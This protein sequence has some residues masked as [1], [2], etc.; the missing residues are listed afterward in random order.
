MKVKLILPLF[1]LSSIFKNSFSLDFMIDSIEAE[2]EYLN[3]FENE[4]K[5]SL[6]SK[7]KLYDYDEDCLYFLNSF[8]E[9][10]PIIN[11]NI[12][13]LS[14][15]A[16]NYNKYLSELIYVKGNIEYLGL[17]TNKP[18][19][20]SGI[21]HFIISGF[22]GNTD[23]LYKL[24]VLIESNI[25]SFYYSKLQVKI[26]EMTI[27]KYI[28][29]EKNYLN[30]FNFQD[31]NEKQN[32]AN[33]LLYTSSLY[34]NINSLNALGHK[35]LKG[36]GVQKDC[37][38]GKK[39]YKESSFMTIDYYMKVNKPIYFEKQNIAFG[40]Y[41]GYRYSTNEVTLDI[42]QSL[43]YYK[44]EAGKGSIHHI[45]H[46]GQRY[47]Y[48]QGVEQNYNEAFNYYSQGTF[49]N[50]TTSMFYLGEMYL[51]GWGCN[52]DYGKAFS[53]FE[54]CIRGSYTKAYNSLG[55]MYYFGLGLEKNVKKAYDY[56]QKAIK[57]N[58]DDS[59]TYFNLLTLLI[60]DNGDIDVDIVNAHKYA[61][62]IASKGH[63]FGSYFL[64]NL[65]EYKLGSILNSC[66]INIEYFR[67]VSERSF[68]SK[69]KFDIAFKSYINKNYRT[70]ALL[71]LEL[72]EEGHLLGEINYGI[73]LNNYDIFNNKT[74][75]LI[76]SHKYLQR[77]SNSNNPIASLYLADIYYIG[78]E[79][80]EVD[81]S[82]A[83]NFY[84]KV[85]KLGGDE[86]ISSHSYFNLGYLNYYGYGVEK[87]I[88]KFG[89]YMK[90]T[91]KND[92]D[93]YIP[94]LIIEN[95]LYIFNLESMQTFE[96]II[97][98]LDNFVF[99]YLMYPFGIISF[100]LSVYLMFFLSL[101]FQN[102]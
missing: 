21:I 20:L 34:K 58:L 93:Y 88:T 56:F 32:I 73:L 72:A 89:K 53:L 90:N 92:P 97:N 48:G 81:Y 24:Y 65:I 1:I 102:K 23:S 94:S 75:N 27:L 18:N 28:L 85:L 51:N 57:F 41:F 31:L 12:K 70:S 101:Y 78:N 66:D 68:E 11:P 19:I 79:V 16:I 43:D 35:Y 44:I 95:Y 82:K 98:T 69:K 3:Q 63:T 42:S 7:C 29:V 61:S 71:Y 36:H 33:T 39:Y 45:N 64:A 74:Y 15:K 9:K 52:K 60:E 22:I 13:R 80:I 49:M 96:L 37:Q 87:N 84:N 86:K 2:N 6:L 76:M 77:A 25:Y 30:N 59:D 38:V 62:L 26:S 50:D 46:L 4:N 14:E 99:P 8:I 54:R 67:S 40:E 83:H 17:L 100:C 10:Y 47:Y 5:E 55:Y 91:V